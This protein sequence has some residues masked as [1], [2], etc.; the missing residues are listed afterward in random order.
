M[1]VSIGRG[2]YIRGWRGLDG[3]VWRIEVIVKMPKKEEKM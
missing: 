2:D 1:R 3:C